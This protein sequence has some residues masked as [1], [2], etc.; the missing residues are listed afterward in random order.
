MGS[1]GQNRP[2]YDVVC[3][4]P[5]NETWARAFQKKIATQGTILLIESTLR[6]CRISCKKGWR[7]NSLHTFMW[8]VEIAEL[9]SHENFEDFFKC[10]GKNTVMDTVEI[11]VQQSFNTF[12]IIKIKFATIPPQTPPQPL[13]A[14][15]RGIFTK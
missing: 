5:C 1:R 15:Q 3:P 12:G 11:S 6:V 4:D 2:E 13:S 10:E 7:A 14:K 8:L 9:R